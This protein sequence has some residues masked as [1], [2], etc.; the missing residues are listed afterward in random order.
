MAEANRKKQQNMKTE[1]VSRLPT[2]YNTRTTIA[3]R[4]I[5]K[6]F[7]IVALDS[8]GIYLLLIVPSAGQKIPTVASKVKKEAKMIVGFSRN[9]GMDRVMV[10][11]IK[12]ILI[13]F[14]T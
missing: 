6:K 5:R 9:I 13:K 7:M 1:V 2:L 11:I 12:T 10:E 4:G 8:S 3:L 14:S